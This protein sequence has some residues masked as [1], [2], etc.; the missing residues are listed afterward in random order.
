[1]NKLLAVTTGNNITEGFHSYLSYAYSQRV[2]SPE[3]E[4]SLFMRY[5]QKNDLDAVRQLILS[6]L[7][8]VAFIAKSYTGYG[9]P[10]EDLVQEGNIGLMKSIK[11]YDIT[12][13]IRLATHAVHWIKSEIHEYVLKNWKLVKVATTKAQRKLFFNLRKAKQHLGW[14]TGEEMREVASYLKVNQEEVKEMEARMRQADVYFDPSFGDA[15]DEAPDPM[16]A[17]SKLLEDHSANP[18]QQ[19]AQADFRI[20]F[21]QTLANALCT[22]P[23]RSRD[24]VQHRV[25]CEDE[26][27]VS[28]KS[29][30]EKYGISQERV[31]QIE[32][33]ALSHLREHLMDAGLSPSVM[34]A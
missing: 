2:L 9:L 16:Q 10:I 30:S 11:R 29:L 14:M 28:L 13:G 4:K 31:R 21:T 26:D 1:M 33:K 12:H 18:E 6:H 17:S 22:L 23:S 7:R 19:T 34:G 27:K 20:H 5:Q 25:L 24:I 32:V 15:R 3:E 8:F